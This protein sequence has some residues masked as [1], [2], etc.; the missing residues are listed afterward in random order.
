VATRDR[1]VATEAGLHA[2]ARRMF[3]R[4]LEQRDV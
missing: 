2:D 3:P 4:L 1:I